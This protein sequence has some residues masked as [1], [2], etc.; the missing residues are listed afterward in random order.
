MKTLVYV[1]A[2]LPQDGDSLLKLATED[3]DRK[4]GLHL[5]IQKDK[6]IASID[7]EPAQ[8]CLPMTRPPRFDKWSRI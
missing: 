3:K 7:Y 4:A 5:Q 6:G 2:Y 1:A 8:I